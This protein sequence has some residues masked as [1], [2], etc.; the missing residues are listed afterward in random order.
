[1]DPDDDQEN[2][3]E[4]LLNTSTPFAPR[5]PED[6]AERL[7]AELPAPPQGGEP[8]GAGGSLFDV[9]V[10]AEFFRERARGP[11]PRKGPAL[12]D[13]ARRVDAERDR[14]LVR[15]RAFAEQSAKVSGRGT[16][17]AGRVTATVD[18][19]LRVVGLSVADGSDITARM[20]GP[21]MGEAIA[22]AQE[23]VKAARKALQA[24]FYPEVPV[25]FGDLPE[26]EGPTGGRR[27]SEPYFTS[28]DRSEPSGARQVLAEALEKWNTFHAS[29]RAPRKQTFT[30]RFAHGGER[31]TEGRSP[32]PAGGVH[33]RGA[34]RLHTREAGPA[35][36]GSPVRAEGRDRGSRTGPLLRRPDR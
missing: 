10:P 30:R 6:V 14:E 17:R 3:L 9:P 4:R 22:R 12:A 32:G 28:G 1:M 29:L 26:Q 25:D 11:A 7:A 27:P 8:S 20:L 19:D 24:Q 23:E 36:R 15:A 33:H 2:P 35:H 34:A 13:L 21:A 31:R 5:D 18:H 16:D